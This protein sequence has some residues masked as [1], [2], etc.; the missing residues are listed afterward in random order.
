MHPYLP[1][2]VTS[3]IERHVLLHS[4]TQSSP[5]TQKLTLTPE[6]RRFAPTDQERTLLRQNLF[7]NPAF[8]GD[9]TDDD[10][11]TIAHFDA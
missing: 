6:A 3:G 10:F 2:I 7:A 1:H 9:E 8:S 4:P 5:C 11:Q